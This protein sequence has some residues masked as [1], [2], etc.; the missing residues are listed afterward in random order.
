[1]DT[2]LIAPELQLER[3]YAGDKEGTF[4][5]AAMDYVGGMEMPQPARKSA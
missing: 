5:D 2:A 4:G 3:L 1:M